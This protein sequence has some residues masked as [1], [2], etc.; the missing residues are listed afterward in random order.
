LVLV[1]HNEQRRIV[2]RLQNLMASRY[3]ADKLDLV[4]VSDGSTDDTVE[5][6]RRL[7]DS[8]VQVLALPVRSGKAHCLNAGIAV[9][10]GEV[11]VFADS[12]QSF[13]PDT[14]PLLVRHFADPKIGAVS[15]ALMID[16]SASAVGTGVDAYWRLE[17]FVR[18]S[19]ARWDSC[20]GC[21]GAVYA[22]RR[23]LFQ[24]IPDDSLL[25]DVVI[26][27]QIALQGYRVEF[28]PAAVAFDPQPLEPDRERIRKRRTLAGNFQMLFRYPHWLVPWVNRLWWQLISHKYLRL[29]APPLLLILLVTNALLNSS[30]V[31][32][33]LFAGQ[34]VFYSLAVL[35]ILLP[36]LRTPV[37]SIPAGFV[38]LNFMTVTGFWHYLT[39]A[40]R[41]GW[42]LTN[43][44]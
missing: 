21:T 7:A 23:E 25:D 5:Q 43:K 41:G 4:V 39:G 37:L 44:G 22:L 34:A 19:E 15:G 11:I 3:P 40:H 28:D 38:F 16:P 17:K 12:R 2:P 18:E 29:S 35:G 1:A 10:R 6:I 9:A 8:H 31:F 33:L 32:R 36:R 20:I 30:P 27:M 26:P 42:E 24:P 14:I 13:A